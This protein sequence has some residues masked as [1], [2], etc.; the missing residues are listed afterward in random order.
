MPPSQNGT[1]SGRLLR[2]DQLF[3]SLYHFVFFISICIA[4][5]IFINNFFIPFK[6]AV[7]YNITVAA[8]ILA[9]QEG[10]DV[11][12]EI[13]ATLILPIVVGVIVGRI[14]KWLDGK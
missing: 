11:R 9:I 8:P 13:L 6:G 5:Y 2:P 14:N 12:M 3:I 10:G 7:W 1:V 4:G